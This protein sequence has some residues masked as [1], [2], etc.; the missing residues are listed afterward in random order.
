MFSEY[1]S[2]LLEKKLLVFQ[3]T[4]ELQVPFL[5]LKLSGSVLDPKSVQTLVCPTGPEMNFLHALKKELAV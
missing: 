5:T 4:L 3:L 1:L 2:K